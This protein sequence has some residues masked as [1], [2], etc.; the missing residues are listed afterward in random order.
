MAESVFGDKAVM[1]DTGALAVALGDAKALW[2]EAIAVSG[3]IGEW[4]FY[5]KAAGWTYPVK[6]GKR[7]L[8]Y[9]MPKDGYFQLTFVY[10][11]RATL[12]AKSTGL[13][14]QV[15]DDLLH[16]KAYVEGRSVQVNIMDAGDME[17]MRKLL[18]IKLAY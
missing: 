5:T 10:G 15:L 9:M 17:T 16:A 12:A 2:D 4:K 1:P 18:E 11:E 7:T 13:P 14:E 3:G 8:F 6:K